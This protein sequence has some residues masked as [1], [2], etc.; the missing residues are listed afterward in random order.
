MRAVFHRGYVLAAFLYFVVDAHL[1]V[2]QITLLGTVMSL[3]LS[4]SD[5]P[6]GAWA[7]AI[8]RRWSLVIGHCL[9]AAGMVM[10]G[11]V[12]RYPLMIATQVLWALGWAFS[13][14]ADVAWL[15]DEFEGQDLG[16]IL[17]A[18]ARLSLAGGA[19]GMLAFGILGW[20]FGLSGAVVVSGAGMALLGVHVAA[21]FRER[22]LNARRKPSS[23]C[24]LLR[25]GFALALRDRVI[26]LVLAATFISESGSI[27]GWLFPKRLA[28]IGFS[29]NLVWSLTVIGILS[30]IVGAASLRVI[31][32]CIKRDESARWI[33]A[34][35][36]LFGVFGVGLLGYGQGVVVVGL[37]MLIARGIAF[38][39][40]RAVSVIWV[41]RR[42]A[43]EV[44]ATVLSCLSQAESLGEIVGG[45]SLTILAQ[46]A[47]L[48]A[49]LLAPAVL[50]SLAGILVTLFG[51]NTNRHHRKRSSS[52]P[53]PCP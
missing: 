20:G 26:L 14:G 21:R 39:I 15:T 6:A 38:N 11:F 17:A 33:Y 43:S 32:A 47:G 53:T 44:R 18:S 30:A 28:N 46:A 1:T 37:G 23:T 24:A 13:E 12:I 48:R 40:T 7:D 52:Q 25:Q 50:F 31:E 34:F 5:I 29:N 51:A 19:T 41:N 2:S 16:R 49:T 4:L 36:C 22:N 10:T 45:F 8:S 9:L 42:T 35:S 3:T 27:I